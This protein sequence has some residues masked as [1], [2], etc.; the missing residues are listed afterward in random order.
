MASLEGELA[1]R[2]GTQFA[3]VVSR[4]NA[5]VTER[6][7]A[8]CLRVMREHGVSDTDVD[9]AWVPG[10]FEIPLAARRMAGAGRYD[11]VICLGC[12]IRGQTPH[13]DYVAD[14]VTTGVARLGCESC[15]P[16]IFGV[17]TTDTIEQA[18][19]RS[20]GE[21]RTKA[22]TASL[23]PQARELVAS[24]GEHA[25]PGTGNKGADAA[26]AAIEMVSLLRKLAQLPTRQQT[27]P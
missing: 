15:L 21:V 2:S 16:V 25:R 26:L 10:A 9:V 8:G 7:L 17:L 14:A 20:G 22:E 23:S 4:F 6:L 5:F 19:E 24:G 1:V 11:A 18:L 27:D 12:V 13:F 3:V